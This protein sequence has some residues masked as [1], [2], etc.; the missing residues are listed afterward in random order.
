[1]TAQL[2]PVVLSTRTCRNALLNKTDIIKGDYYLGIQLVRGSLQKADIDAD[3]ETRGPCS[4]PNRSRYIH[5]IAI[6]LFRVMC[7]FKRLTVM[8]L[9]N[10]LSL[11]SS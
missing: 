1:M 7:P 2:A 5:F 8:D 6:F 4:N 9:H 11:G 10:F 3:N